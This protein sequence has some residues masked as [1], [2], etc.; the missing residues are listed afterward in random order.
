MPKYALNHD[1]QD[2]RPHL[3]DPLHKLIFGSQLVRMLPDSDVVGFF[4]LFPTILLGLREIL[5]H[6]FHLN[7]IN[8]EWHL[9]M[10]P[11]DKGLKAF[12]L[13]IGL[14]NVFFLCRMFSC[15]DYQ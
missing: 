3:I 15:L 12:R 10:P 5:S 14:I 4:R 11:V 7:H 9:W 8:N 2:T 1:F 6:I 13:I